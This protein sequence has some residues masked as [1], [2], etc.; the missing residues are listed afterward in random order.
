MTW[1]WLQVRAKGRGEQC[2]PPLN[3]PLIVRVLAVLGFS[4]E[5]CENPQR[6]VI[7]VFDLGNNV[8][9]VR[10]RGPGAVWL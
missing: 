8:F 2:P 6:F 4:C 1:A 10:L 5:G 9:T 7:T 3:N